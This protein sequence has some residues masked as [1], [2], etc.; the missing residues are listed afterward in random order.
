MAKEIELEAGDKVTCPYCGRKIVKFVAMNVIKNC[1]CGARI[2]V[3][4]Y[5]VKKQN[6]IYS[7]Q[8]VSFK[9]PE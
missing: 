8:R 7:R 1:E 5:M 9:K 4:P 3:T 6:V 2:V